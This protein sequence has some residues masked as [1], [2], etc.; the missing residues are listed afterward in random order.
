MIALVNKENE[1]V[2]VFTIFLPRAYNLLAFIVTFRF[3]LVGFFMRATRKLEILT[4]NNSL[5]EKCLPNN[6]SINYYMQFIPI[7]CIM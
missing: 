6:L 2:S 1:R 7:K 3:I 5:S 4:N